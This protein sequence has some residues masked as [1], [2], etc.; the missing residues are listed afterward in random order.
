MKKY[1]KLKNIFKLDEKK[2]KSLSKGMKTQLAF[3]LNISISPKVLILDEP[4][5]GWIL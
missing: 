2:I 4:T 1:I 3:M 5:S